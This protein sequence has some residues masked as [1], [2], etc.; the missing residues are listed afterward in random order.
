MIALTHFFGFS[1]EPFAQDIP[2]KNLYPLP[3]LAPLLE[4]FDY[5]VANRM[6]TVI[7]LENTSRSGA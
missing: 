4:R 7:I 3:A 5:A 2:I 6:A 1:R